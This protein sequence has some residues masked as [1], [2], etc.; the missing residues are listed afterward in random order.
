ME[1]D[2]PQEETGWCEESQ[3][4]DAIKFS[5]GWVEDD[6]LLTK[7]D[8]TVYGE[9]YGWLKDQALEVKDDLLKR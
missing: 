9:C 7:D 6:V 3:T 8:L 1:D 5:S 4:E 2:L